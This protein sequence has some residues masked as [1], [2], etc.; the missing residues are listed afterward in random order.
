ML[1]I[2]SL[3]LL[4]E[5]SLTYE[6][7]P[8]D[9]I[10]IKGANGSG[11]S[12]F[13]KTISRLLPHEG[14]ELSFHGKDSSLYTPEYWRS[15]I[16]YVP[17]EVSTSDDYSVEDFLN[18]PFTLQRYKEIKPAFNPREH[19]KGFNLQMRLLSSGQK[20]KL[21]LLRALSLDAD[22]LL[23]DE[24]FSHMDESSRSES[25]TLL[26]EWV[27]TKKIIF[28][29]SHFDMNAGQFGTRELHL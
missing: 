16:L 23:L 13:L 12:L 2:T 21:A 14:G 9:L 11:K 27:S 25:M 22:I 8:S 5:K 6:A 19:F 24:T 17:P 10:M 28:I 29:V 3:K 7:L 26:K 20:Q 1:K 4:N 15:K 18:E